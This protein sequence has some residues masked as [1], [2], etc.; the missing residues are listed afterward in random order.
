MER[1]GKKYGQ[2]EGNAKNRVL[3][4]EKG[5]R[6]KGTGKGTE[7]TPK[8]GQKPRKGGGGKRDK[9]SGGGFGKGELREKTPKKKD[10]PKT[11]RRLTKKKL[12]EKKGVGDVVS[13]NIEEGSQ[14]RRKVNS[15]RKREL[16]GEVQHKKKETRREGGQ[17]HLCGKKG[18][19]K[20]ER[21]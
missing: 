7:N 2:Q 11:S 15:R 3:G 10:D 4:K 13:Q 5:V 1:G 17:L 9:A 6:Q 12:G 8:R 20:G 21:K 16:R 18:C 19:R 14:K